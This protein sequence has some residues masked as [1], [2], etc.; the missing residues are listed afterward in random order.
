MKQIPFSKTI[1]LTF[2]K[3]QPT[4]AKDII[5]RKIFQEKEIRNS[6]KMLF[7]K[8]PLLA[9]GHWETRSV[10]KSVFQLWL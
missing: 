8:N 10:G 9:N 4:K 7:W 6:L 5:A 1:S 3:K 2:A